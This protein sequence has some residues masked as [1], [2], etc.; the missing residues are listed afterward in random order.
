MTNGYGVEFYDADDNGIGDIRY[1]MP[2]DGPVTLEVAEYAEVAHVVEG[3]PVYWDA[4]AYHAAGE[5]AD[6]ADGFTSGLRRDG[7]TVVG[8]LMALTFRGEVYQCWYGWLYAYAADG[9][10]TGGVSAGDGLMVVDWTTVLSVEGITTRRRLMITTG[11]LAARIRLAA[12][13]CTTALTRTPAI[14]LRLGSVCLRISW[15]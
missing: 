14:M 3:A 11:L 10:M 12:L 9:G 5:A 6:M 1:N 2:D 13:L 4:S 15:V 7:F 8:S